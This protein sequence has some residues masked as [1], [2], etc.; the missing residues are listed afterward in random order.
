M[1]CMPGDA[2]V[3]EEIRVAGGSRLRR[4]SRRSARRSR[5]RCSGKSG[6][7]A[8]SIVLVALR[9]PSSRLL[10]RGD[11]RGVLGRRPSR[12]RPGRAPQPGDPSTPAE[13]GDVGRP[14]V[15]CM[16]VVTASRYSASVFVASPE[17]EPP[18]A[19]REQGQGSRAS[20]RCMCESS[21]SNLGQSERG[22]ERE[23]RLAIRGGERAE[24][25]H[26]DGGLRARVVVHHDGLL[27]R[28]WRA[29]RAS[30]VAIEAEADERRR[31]PVARAR[32]A[33]RSCRRRAR[34][35]CRAGAS[36]CRPGAS[37]S[38]SCAIG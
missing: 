37:M 28:A 6:A 10:H 14:E 8:P 26:R 21:V 29:R 33:R 30:S 19:D 20:F 3:V 32:P 31:A 15:S 17:S 12:A 9:A 38:A 2:L 34:R 36:R 24:S 35:P 5:R 4:G 25:L 22:D 18:H 11:G 16:P 7:M 13:R 27:D 1:A 23:E